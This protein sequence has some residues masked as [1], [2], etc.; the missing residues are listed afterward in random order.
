MGSYTSQGKNPFY[1]LMRSRYIQYN[2]MVALAY[3][4]RNRYDDRR[5]IA[6]LLFL[7]TNFPPIWENYLLDNISI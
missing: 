6:Q 1:S 7:I 2:Y 4:L 3:I 5:L